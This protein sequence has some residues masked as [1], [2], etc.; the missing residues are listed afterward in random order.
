MKKVQYTVYVHF[1]QDTG[2]VS[3]ASCSCVAGQGGLCKYVA[4][5]LYAYTALLYAYMLTLAWADPGINMPE[6][7]GVF[8]LINYILDK[9]QESMG[10]IFIPCSLSWIM[11]SSLK[12]IN[13][14]YFKR[15]LFKW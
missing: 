13:C 10:N 14:Q 3:T 9:L 12:L 1:Y 6:G 2:K 11:Y 7:E 4:V 8:N 5:L 15:V